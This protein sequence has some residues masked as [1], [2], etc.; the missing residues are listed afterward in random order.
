MI[1]SL[2]SINDSNSN[3]SS[4]SNSTALVWLHN[5]STLFNEVQLLCKTKAQSPSFY[6]DMEILSLNK[7]CHLLILSV[8]EMGFKD[9]SKL[10][11][12][13]I[14]KKKN[15][16][17]LLHLDSSQ[18]TINQQIESSY[19]D[20]NRINFIDKLGSPREFY[21]LI[22]SLI[23]KSQLRNNQ[24]QEKQGNFISIKESNADNKELSSLIACG[25][26]HDVNNILTAIQGRVWY[27][28]KI[29]R[30]QDHE[31]YTITPK[32]AFL[33][34]SRWILKI[35]SLLKQLIEMSKEKA[36]K[37]HKIDL[38]NVLKS[39]MELA[40]SLICESVKVTLRL[41]EQ[42]TPSMGDFTLLEQVILNLCINAK[43]AMIGDGT[44]EVK[45]TQNVKIDDGLYHQ[46]KLT[47][48]GKGISSSDLEHIFDPFFSTD[49]KSKGHGLGLFMCKQ[50]IEKHHGFIE[51][52]S[53]LNEGSIFT[54]NIPIYN[55]N[56]LEKR[57][58]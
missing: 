28:E 45:L 6:E 33:D 31:S 58:S 5:S 36:F 4:I 32:Q 10:V 2:D 57:I 49:K 48:N 34:V 54:I 53:H 39:S 56:Q 1:K 51:V 26:A 14:L 23:S 9:F 18:E 50:I 7:T 25:M 12:T 8:G 43:N 21:F 52:Q 38:N 13:L 41:P 3:P 40:N 27:L 15:S 44:L 29:A 24:N 22:T 55:N 46:I 11:D 16:E 42:K 30:I 35:K 17:V 19:S 47:D 20:R 37:Q